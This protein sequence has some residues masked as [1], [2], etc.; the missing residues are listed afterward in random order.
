[1][2]YRDVAYDVHAR[3][4]LNFWQ[5]KGDGARPLVVLIHGGGWLGRDKREVKDVTKY[6]EKGISVAAINYRY[7]SIAPL[8]APV[9]DAARAVQF[10]RYKA[11]DW[12]IDKNRIV[13]SG[14]SAGG[15]S[16]VLIACMPDLAK[17]DSEDPIERESTRIQGAA[18]AGAQVSVDPKQLAEWVGEE[19]AYHGM[20]VKAVGEETAE[21]MLQNYAKHGATFKEFSAINHLSQDDPPVFFAY[22]SDLTVPATS[23]GHAIH[24]GLFGVKFKEQSEAV[25]H[26]NVHLA[27]GK[28]YTSA[29][30]SPDDFITKTLL[31]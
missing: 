8:P 30:A 13:L 4:K 19:F 1:M 12:N 31:K 6:I 24:H 28:A 3:T 21:A 25:G 17:P 29:Y 18:G 16:S 15:C 9:L 20:I 2:T 11:A 23:Y 22:S 5:A 10:L 14:D 27:I 26:N 7:S